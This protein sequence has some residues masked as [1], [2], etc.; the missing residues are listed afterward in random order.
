MSAD[1]AGP[2]L[3]N[4]RKPFCRRR[5]VRREKWDD[6]PSDFL[7]ASSQKPE[8]SGLSMKAFQLC[9]C[10]TARQGFA[11]QIQAAR[12][13]QGELASPLRDNLKRKMPKGMPRDAGFAPI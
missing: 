2:G 13:P 7:Y 10:R 5:G 9:K 12:L 11:V 4:S 6:F 3:Q 1:P 8:Q